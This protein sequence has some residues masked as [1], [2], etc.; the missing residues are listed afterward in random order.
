MGGGENSR[1]AGTSN[2][3]ESFWLNLGSMISSKPFVQKSRPPINTEWFGKST[4]AP[5]PKVV[6]T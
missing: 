3:C 4:M 1:N 2:I 5:G 6:M